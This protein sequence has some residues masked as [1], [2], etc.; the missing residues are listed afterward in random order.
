MALGAAHRD[1][2]FAAVG[3]ATDPAAT[4]A[5]CIGDPAM[6]R[7]E[8]GCRKRREHERVRGN[9]NRNASALVAP[10]P[11]CNEEV[12]VTAIALCAGRAARL[13]SVATGQED[14][15]WSLRLRRPAG[16]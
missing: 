1:A 7:A 15:A 4:Y 5:I 6:D 10:E 8:R 14:E 16:E 9:R 11:S 2:V 13:A 3:L 12:G